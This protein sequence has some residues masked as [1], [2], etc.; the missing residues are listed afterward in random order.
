YSSTSRWIRSPSVRNFS[1]SRPKS[2]TR[3]SIWLVE[4][5]DT[6]PS[7]FAEIFGRH[8]VILPLGGTSTRQFVNR[9]LELRSPVVSGHGFPLAPTDPFDLRVKCDRSVTSPAVVNRFCIWTGVS[10]R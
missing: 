1:R 6:R 9:C 2:P 8:L 3:S 7:D 10:D 4:L 5:F